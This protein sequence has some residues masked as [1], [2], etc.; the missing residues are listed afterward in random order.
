MDGSRAAPPT[1]AMMLTKS[2]WLHCGLLVRT[3]RRGSSTIC[4]AVFR[5]CDHSAKRPASRAYSKA[6]FAYGRAM[7]A[8]SATGNLGGQFVQQLGMRLGIYFPAQQA[9]RAFH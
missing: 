9:R 3:A 5:P 6:A 2:A 4:A 7:V 8:R 1:S